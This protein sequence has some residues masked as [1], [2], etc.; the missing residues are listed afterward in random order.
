MTRMCRNEAD[1]R[2][3]IIGPHYHWMG[4]Q[5]EVCPDA[6]RCPTPSCHPVGVVCGTGTEDAGIPK[7]HRLR[8]TLD[9]PDPSTIVGVDLGT[10]YRNVEAAI[11]RSADRDGIRAR[12]AAYASE[13]AS[14]TDDLVVTLYPDD[15]PSDIRIFGRILEGRITDPDVLRAHAEA[16]AAARFGGHH[17]LPALLEAHPDAR[18][19]DLGPWGLWTVIDTC[20]PDCEPCAHP[21]PVA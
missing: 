6:E 5:Y 4:D 12:L 8:L 2:P 13:A 18:A 11:E 9:M 15:G 21:E 16:R 17:P 1:P 7:L 19:A 14:G 3:A 20:Y 10:V